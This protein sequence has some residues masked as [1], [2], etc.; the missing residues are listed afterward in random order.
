LLIPP[1]A[2]RDALLALLPRID[3]LL[4]TGGA[5]IDPRYMNE[6]PDYTLLHGINAQRDQQELLLAR[7]ADARCMPILGICR[8]MQILNVAFGGNL[9]QIITDKNLHYKNNCDTIHPI[10][11]NGGFM[12]LIYGEQL[13]TNS[14][15][16]QAV[17]FLG[18]N[19][20]SCCYSEDILC[21]AFEH[22]YSN[23]LGVQFH[24]ERMG[25]L[26]LYIYDYFL[27]LN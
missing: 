5:D 18:K 24:P 21:E 8:G 14:A 26:G 25:V 23:I 19:L 15:H 27:N 2:N 22:K 17:N 12:K 20:V 11:C 3:A 16:R 6:E 4:L 10:E 9:T 1:F 7:L 13:M